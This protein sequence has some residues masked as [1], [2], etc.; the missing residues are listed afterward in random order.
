M[1]V[2][3][4]TVAVMRYLNEQGLPEIPIAA[5]HRRLLAT[6]GLVMVLPGSGVQA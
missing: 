1:S 5:D 3:P 4:T 2:Y 6:F